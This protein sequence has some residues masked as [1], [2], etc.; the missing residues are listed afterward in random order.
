MFREKRRAVS[1]IQ[2]VQMVGPERE[3][4]AKLRSLSGQGE[5]KIG[6][7]G[8]VGSLRVCD[9]IIR[10]KQTCFQKTSQAK[11]LRTLTKATI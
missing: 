1:E 7:L 8:A 5:P 2:Q 6:G 9:I 3:A 10:R 4:E 11:E